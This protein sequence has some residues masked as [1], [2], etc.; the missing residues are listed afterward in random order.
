MEFI[1]DSFEPLRPYLSTDNVGEATGLGAVSRC[2]EWA[3]GY[4]AARANMVL[5]RR[6]CSTLGEC[7]DK[8]RQVVD[9]AESFG[10]FRFVRQMRR[11]GDRNE[12]H[13]EVY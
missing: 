12:R 7:L 13:R 2:H 11:N 3:Q 10:I 1:E 4:D 9:S 5:Y 8:E 6:G